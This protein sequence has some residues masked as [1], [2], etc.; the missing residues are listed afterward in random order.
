[1][2]KL[3]LIIFSI[4]S[5]VTTSA[6]INTDRVMMIGRN[7]LYFEDYVLA[8][9]YFNQIIKSK[10]YLAEP[11]YYRAISKYFLDDFK[12]AE[13]DCTLSIERN[14]FLYGAYQLR[15]DSRQNQKNYGG[16]EEDYEISLKQNPN[17]KFILINLGIVNIENKDFDKAE[18]YLNQL[19]N[20]YPSFTE[21][22]LTR[23]NLYLE[24]T[25][26]IKAVED[27]NNAIKNDKYFA[28]AYAM[29]A[30]VELMQ[31]QYENA[32]KDYDKTIELD[33]LATGYYINRGLA[34]YYT[35]DLRG[36]MS[37][38]DHVIKTD[39]DNLIAHFNRALLRSQ[40]GDDNKAIEDFNFV[41][42]NEPE[43]YIAYM[44]RALVKTNIGDL[45]GAL[46]DLNK[47]LAEYPNFYQG[48]QFRSDIKRRQN[49]MRGAEQD[50]NT[51][52]R[53]EN[54]VKQDI[55]AGRTPQGID[56]ST[57]TREE[58]DKTIDKFNRL[59]VTDKDKE[60][61]NIYKSETR[62]KVQNKQASIDLMPIFIVSYYD[63]ENKTKNFIHFNKELED[64]NKN[65]IFDQKLIITN[66]D[67]QLD[68]IQIAERFESINSFS[69]LITKEPENAILYFARGLDYMLIQD[70]SSATED[71]NRSIVID[72]SFTLAYFNLGAAYEK[73]LNVKLDN[74][75][76]YLP[77]KPND[78]NQQY[79]N[80]NNGLIN[81]TAPA[82]NENAN[83]L[84]SKIEN[85]Q[86]IDSYNKVLEISPNFIYAYYNRA[87]IKS[88]QDDAR[89]AILD[90]NEAIRR[91]P[92]F[93]D[94]YYNRGINRLKIK[95]TQRGIEDLRKA[96]EL[97]IVS[98]YSI[99]KRM[100]E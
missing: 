70:Y 69:S 5:I 75:G 97:G 17:D 34:K 13:E 42:K 36:A 59:V 32:L 68:S 12:G 73:M 14:Q 81:T 63:D 3:V 43:N 87:E 2:K 98:A 31:K 16:A 82:N 74:P 8:I 45:R 9:Q 96:G 21:G 48:Y 55:L 72:P 29:R 76:L 25:D 91:D 35:N 95:D 77:N 24:K 56:E 41:L 15:A 100:T 78:I 89:G 61:K 47:V 99:M 84:I 40:V 22:I 51:A 80:I 1:M 11:Y 57:K 27:I 4:L 65:T 33:P 46:S 20:T 92:D 38:Y 19:V 18:G 66:L 53:I 7:A 64:L 52:L 37:D 94:A 23:A 86:I 49:D 62:G 60:E 88:M 54:K 90:Y 28:P 50:Y 71:F 39:P 30:S 44:N 58:S 67:V 10:P 26:T 93:A 6:Q 85:D 83:L 79:Q